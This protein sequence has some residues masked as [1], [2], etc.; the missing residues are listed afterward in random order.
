MSTDATV[1]LNGFT[2]GTGTKYAID[3]NGIKGLGL[4]DAK[5]AD[6]VFDGRDGVFAAPDFLGPRIITFGLILL[7]DDPDD[8]LSLL[9]D[10]NAAWSPARDGVDIPLDITISAWA[11]TFNGRARG[12]EADTTDMKSSTFTALCMFF[13]TNPN[14][15]A[16]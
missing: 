2:M 11:V 5:T 14:N 3:D 15:V 13:A 4:P 7:G 10:L 16:P 9:D 12:V 8:A 6:T 1:V